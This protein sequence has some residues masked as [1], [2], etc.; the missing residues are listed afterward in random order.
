MVFTVSDTALGYSTIG[1]YT[2][3]NRLEKWNSG[4]MMVLE[5][6]Y[7]WFLVNPTTIFPDN[8]KQPNLNGEIEGARD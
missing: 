8:M 6:E 3:T 5:L 1:D 2:S 4:N 7:L